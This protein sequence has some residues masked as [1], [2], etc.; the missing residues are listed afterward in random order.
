MTDRLRTAAA[1]GSSALATAVAASL[2]QTQ[3]TLL[4]LQRLGVP[5]GLAKR[6]AVSAEDVAR[7]A[8][9]M[10]AFTLAAVLI[11]WPLQ[12]LLQRW[13][14][15][16]SGWLIANTLALAVVMALLRD[17][18]PMP[19]IAATRSATGLALVSLCGLIGG[20]VAYRVSTQRHARGAVT[21]RGAALLLASCVLLPAI[22]FALM[23][24]TPAQPPV[25]LA[26]GYRSE[27]LLQGLERPWSLAELPDG[28]WLVT[29][30]PGRLQRLES[31]GSLTA[32]AVD[33]LPAAYYRGRTI[34][35]MEVALSPDFAEDQRIYLTQGYRNA[36]GVGIVLLRA[37]LQDGD[38]SPRLSDVETLFESTPKARDS[39]NGGRVAFVDRSTVLLTVGDG[40]ARREEAQNPDNS[41]GKVMQLQVPAPG[42][43]ASTPAQVTASIYSHGHRNPQGIVH[44]PV[45]GAFFVT[46]HGPRGGDEL[47]R[48]QAG[49][50]HGWPLVSQGLDYPFARVS[51]FTRL[52]GLQD[53]EEVW[54]PSIAPSGLTV[55]AGSL[56]AG[57]QGDFLVPALR[58]RGIRRIIRDGERIVGQQRLLAELDARIRDVRAARDGSLYVLTDGEDGRLLRLTPMSVTR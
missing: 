23:R 19:A 58:E 8:P 6:L 56:F 11:A 40:N 27:T 5:V 18:I 12:A 53:A 51:P 52:P 47:N 45:T 34:G 29:E 41:L 49:G 26:D 44:D 10:C 30:M 9:V 31:D 48:L 24:P 21:A 35:L 46:E 20:Y 25:P 33:A 37:R 38:G 42:D 22:S 32:I 14:R 7:F 54:T 2:L 3:L 15:A 57:W 50:N 55:Y 13:L 17:V 39:N 1:L 16:L 43:S 28:R 36:H 4:E